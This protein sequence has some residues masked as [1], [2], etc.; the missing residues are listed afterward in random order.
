MGVGWRDADEASQCHPGKVA[1]AN[2]K[3]VEAEREPT[4]HRKCC[5]HKWEEGRGEEGTGGG[6]RSDALR[7]GY[8]DAK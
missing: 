1:L 3:S 7:K 6:G 8:R 4:M 2:G 5:D